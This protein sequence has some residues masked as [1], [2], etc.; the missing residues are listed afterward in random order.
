MLVNI[1]CYEFIKQFL[2]MSLLG[3]Q[4]IYIVLQIE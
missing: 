2:S 1:G 3:I 4:H